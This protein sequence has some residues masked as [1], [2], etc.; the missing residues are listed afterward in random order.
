M[1]RKDVNYDFVLINGGVARVHGVSKTPYSS[2]GDTV[3]A[4]AW[5]H[6][7]YVVKNG[8]IQWYRNGEAVGNPLRGRL[9]EGN[10]NPLVLGNYEVEPSEVMD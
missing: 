5:Q 4:E 7:A 10:S 9:G 6:V 3:T 2:P 8:T 1:F